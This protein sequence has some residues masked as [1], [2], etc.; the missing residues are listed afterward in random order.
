MSEISAVM[1]GQKREKYGRLQEHDNQER[2][3]SEA[4]S[5]PCERD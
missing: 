2:E 4:D 1:Y 5:S 3:R